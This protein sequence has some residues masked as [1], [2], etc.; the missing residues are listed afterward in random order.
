[1]A[2]RLANADL[3]GAV[4]EVV[5]CVCVDRVGVEGMV[6]KETKG[7]LE[8]LGRDGRVRI[9]GKEGTVFRIE[10]PVEG[11]VGEAEK[12]MVFEVYGSQMVYRSGERA[13][14]KFKMKPMR[15]L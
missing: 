14:R 15:D 6:V 2:Q 12:K 5:R 9:L 11:K 7:G 3:H 1:M 13:G 4:V 10:V 8:V